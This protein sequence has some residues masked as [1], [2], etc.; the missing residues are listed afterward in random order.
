[1]YGQGERGGGNITAEDT[2]GRPGIVGVFKQEQKIGDGMP[3]T[4][5]VRRRGHVDVRPG[6]AGSGHRSPYV[7]IS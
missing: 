4:R 1:M 7:S 2:G 3:G 5:S 6:T